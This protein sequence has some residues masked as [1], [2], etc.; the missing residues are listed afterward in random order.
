MGLLGPVRFCPFSY[1]HIRRHPSITAILHANNA[2]DMEMDAR[3]GTLTFA[4]ACVRPSD[5][6]FV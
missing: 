2:R 4:R 3:A 1:S 5:C 6:L